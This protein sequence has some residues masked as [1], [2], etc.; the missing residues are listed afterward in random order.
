MRMQFGAGL[1]ITAASDTIALRDFTQ[2]LDGA[3]FDVLTSAGHLLGVPAERYMD[4]PQATYAGP[5]YDPF[6]AFGY[7]AAI[8][9]RIHFRPNILIL[10]LYPTAIVAKQGA[11]LQRLSNGRFELGAGISWNAAEY[12]AV[13]QDFSNR[14][15]RLEEQV[16][17]LRKFWSEPYVSFAGKW[18]ALDGVGLNR[19]PTTPIPIWIG[20]AD[21]RVLRR[22]ARLADGFTPLGDPFTVVPIVQGY[23]R[24][25]GRDVSSFGFAARLVAGGEVSEWVA[26]A[27]KL[28]GV[29]VT[30]LTL[31]A[32]PELTGEAALKRLIEARGALADALG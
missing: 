10:P 22:A 32:P 26:T 2:A 18:H 27:R 19:V 17:V 4:R 16:L 9:Q 30:Q 25:A 15:L 6:V 13:G 5:F 14:G 31:S 11:E 3:G 1:P 23:V 21:D 12:Q 29:G 20:G 28:A 8:T 7:L 24:E